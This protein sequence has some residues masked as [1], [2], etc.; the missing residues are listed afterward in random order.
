M[1]SGT[2]WPDVPDVQ[3]LDCTKCAQNTQENSKTMPLDEQTG[4]SI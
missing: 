4:L 3:S 1:D 2:G